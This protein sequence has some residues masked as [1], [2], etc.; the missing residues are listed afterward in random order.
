MNKIK[1]LS[2]I[3]FS[4]FLTG[5]A[6]GARIENMVYSDSSN[7][8]YAPELKQQVS[9]NEVRGGKETN[10]MWKSQISNES[11]T[12]A[13]KRS[14]E[15]QG[16]YANEGKY[17]LTVDIIDVD[18]PLFG[19]DMTVTTHIKYE[20]TDRQSNSILFK[21]MILASYTATMTDAIIGEERL[22]LANEGS[23]KENIKKFLSEL[24]N[25]NVKDI[26]IN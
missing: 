8:T 1:L 2:I 18:Q 17:I 3:V 9:V 25:L 21:K 23:G 22:R 12:F 14:L 16:L 20:L 13:L 15:T 11:F 4:I 24:A 10:P 7:K 5:C 19:P 26:S 6:T